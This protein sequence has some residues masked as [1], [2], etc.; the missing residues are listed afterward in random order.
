M[1]KIKKIVSFI[2]S[3]AGRIVTLY[4]ISSLVIVGLVLFW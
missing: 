4:V 3:E 1:N 2:K